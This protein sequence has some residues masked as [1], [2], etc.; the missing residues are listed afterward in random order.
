M[1]VG[2]TRWEEYTHMYI[3]ESSISRRVGNQ[4]ASRITEPPFF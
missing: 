4:R 3:S 2:G 1:G